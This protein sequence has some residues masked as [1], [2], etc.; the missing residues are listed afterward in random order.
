MS[1]SWVHLRGAALGTREHSS[2]C[3]A[4]AAS[5]TH[6]QGEVLILSCSAS[7]LPGCG[8]TPLQ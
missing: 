8:A 3:F 6:W 1:I 5:S 7:W 4:T 2:L